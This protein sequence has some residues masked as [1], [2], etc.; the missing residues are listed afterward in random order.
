[1]IEEDP[2][3]ING[4]IEFLQYLQKFALVPSQKIDIQGMQSK[5]RNFSVENSHWADSNC[6]YWNASSMLMS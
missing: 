6:I 2:L 4:N 1:M 3:F 5:S